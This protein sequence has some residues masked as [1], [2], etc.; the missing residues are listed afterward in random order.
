MISDTQ[1]EADLATIFAARDRDDMEPTIRALLAIL[2]EHPEE[3]SVLYAVG[4]A[5]DTA[6]QEETALSYYEHALGNGLHGDML[7]KC[8]L[9]YGS[10]LHNVGRIEDS[11]AVFA[12][13]R[14]EFPDSE[15][16]AIFEALTLHAAGRPSAALGQMLVLMAAR[17]Q[18]EE[19]K[20][21]EASI[22]GNAAY[23]IALD[24][25]DATNDAAPR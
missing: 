3:A 2:D 6:G 16:L 22:R 18:S 15:S 21:Y 13:A 8:Y 24:A 9:Q 4:G 1:L 11:L 10:T 19:V 7:P 14:T 20:R 23:L 25:P 5:Y 12:R 17:F